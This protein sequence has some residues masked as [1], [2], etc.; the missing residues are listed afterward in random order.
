[1]KIPQEYAGMNK[2]QVIRTYKRN[3]PG[4]KPMDIAEAVSKMLGE[5]VKAGF[6]STVLS[7]DKRKA[8]TKKNPRTSS[9][10]KRSVAKN[11][12]RS[13][14]DQHAQ[15]YIH[16]IKAAELVGTA[17]VR[18]ICDVLDSISELGK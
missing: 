13:S 16:A 11:D 6:V 10:P 4:Q 12:D 7:N 17:G 1:M 9:T 14:R 2:S 3:N 18:K 15:A 5:E 8:K